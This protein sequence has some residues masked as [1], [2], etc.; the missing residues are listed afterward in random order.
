VSEV[1]HRAET[2]FWSST[3]AKITY[4]DPWAAILQIGEYTL[5]CADSVADAALDWGIIQRG[6]SIQARCAWSCLDS[7]VSSL[8]ASAR[9]V[10]LPFSSASDRAYAFPSDHG[11]YAGPRTTAVIMKRVRPRQFQSLLSDFTDQD[12]ANDPPAEPQ[13]LGF[14][15]SHNA[16]L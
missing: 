8:A 12:G 7:K 16:C 2:T 9:P 11:A 13:R 3:V 14:C 1:Q 6:I 4:P 10:R 15:A 5:D